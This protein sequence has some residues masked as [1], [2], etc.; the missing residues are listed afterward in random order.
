MIIET[1]DRLKQLPPYLFVGIDNKKRELVEKGLDV[2]DLGVGDPDLGTPKFIIDK[3]AEAI[4][5]PANHRYPFQRGVL[6]FRAQAARWLKARFD[7]EFDPETEILTLI[8]TKEGIGHLPLALVNPGDV[9]LVPEPGYPVYQSASIFAGAEVH[10]MPLLESND[11]L[12]DLQSIPPDVLDRA[13]LMFLN[14]PNNPT[15]A[16]ASEAF[17]RQA[18]EFAAKHEIIIAQ[19][20]AYAEVYFDQ[21]PMSIL[22][23]E[24]ARELAIELHSLSKT[25]NMTGWRLAFAVGNA[26]VTAALA[27]LKENVDSGQFNAIQWAGVEALSNADHVEVKA[28]L[29]IYRE[30]RDG[31]VE[32][33]RAAGIDVR[34]PAATFYVWGKCPEGYT[35]MDFAA[36][37]LQEANV[38]LIPGIGFGTSGEGYFRAALTVDVERIKQ[39]AQRIVEI[40]W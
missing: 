32:G 29:D 40:K 22:Q 4:Y 6:E 33:L 2:I 18:V 15:A 38:V 20:A 34:S 3:M 10:Q 17:Y 16:V 27:K 23:V 37:V 8:G 14:Y 11:F 24:G 19:D 36:K 26:A 9:V 12:P 5:D 13:R 1:A 25:F 30:R 35:S 39:A 21:R 28:L 7:I 31:L